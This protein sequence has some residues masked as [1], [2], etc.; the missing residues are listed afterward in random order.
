MTRHS[1]LN[2]SSVRTH[3]VAR[4]ATAAGLALVLVLGVG[5]CGSGDDDDSP[6]QDETPSSVGS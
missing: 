6:T 5:A 2:S 1:S 3:S 4:R